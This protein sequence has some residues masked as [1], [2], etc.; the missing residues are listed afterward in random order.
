[1]YPHARFH[2]ESGDAP[3]LQDHFLR[4]RHCEIV[5]AR[6]FAAQPVEDLQF[7]PL[8]REQLRVV[9]GADSP[10]ARKRKIAL[11]DL[12]DAPWIISANEAGEHSPIAAAFRSAGISLK[13]A[14]VLTG[15]LNLRYG[16]LA[17][18]RFVTVAPHSLLRFGSY[19]GGLKVLPIALP[20]WREPTSLITI[21]GRTLSPLARE[22]VDVVRQLA[23]P[24][25]E[26]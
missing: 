19:R 11:T 17:T 23:R 25:A 2:V 12:R 16:L 18:G 21:R 7:E 4:G 15:S 13:A 9:A 1:R 24:L 10:W 6:S 22:F 8:F 26:A 3:V 14:C 5:I 20:R